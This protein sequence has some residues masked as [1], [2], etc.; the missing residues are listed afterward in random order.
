MTIL[1]HLDHYEAEHKA[2]TSGKVMTDDSPTL[3]QHLYGLAN[4]NN[5]NTGTQ[6]RDIIR[7][8]SINNIL[9]QRHIDDL[10]KQNLRTQKLVKALTIAAVLIGI[11]QIWFAYKSHKR[12]EVEAKITLTPSPLPTTKTTSSPN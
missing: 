10:N 5:T 3:L 11:P 7:G 4:Q 1:D 8:I 9:M 12:A 2:F 6:H